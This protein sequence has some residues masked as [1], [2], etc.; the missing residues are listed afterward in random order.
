MVITETAKSLG[1]NVNELAINRSTVRRHRLEFRAA[2]IKEKFQCNVPLVVH[3][4]GMLIKDL[5]GNE[6]V[7]RLPVLVTGKMFTTTD[8]C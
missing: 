7:D 5:T 1:Q 2:V 3:W 4:V 6:K 8:S